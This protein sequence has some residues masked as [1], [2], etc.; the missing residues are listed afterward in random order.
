MATISVIVV[1]L[2]IGAAQ[3][4]DTLF[5]EVLAMAGLFCLT[6]G[7]VALSIN[8]P[9]RT[10][11]DNFII[12]LAFDVFAIGYVV[13][14][15]MLSACRERALPRF[16]T[17]VLEAIFLRHPSNR[18]YFTARVKLEIVNHSAPSSTRL[19]QAIVKHLDGHR[20]FQSTS[21]FDEGPAP[22]GEVNLVTDDT[23][24]PLGGKRT[25]WVT[26]GLS[27][28]PGTDVSHFVVRQVILRFFDYKDR[29]F[30]VAFPPD[31]W[32]AAG[33]TFFSAPK[34]STVQ[35]DQKS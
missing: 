31:N 1:A 26:F 17:R 21:M 15:Q 18:L 9:P 11:A 33:A 34:L 7:V 16:E 10:P 29:E 13:I 3:L 27:A 22:N 6:V 20:E 14:D 4:R 30:S 28:R 2:W 25:G 12:G 35:P 8:W 32:L 5:G 19:W 24:I 23:P